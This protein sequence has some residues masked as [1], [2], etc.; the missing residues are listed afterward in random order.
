M[1]IP[2]AHPQP[3]SPL[4]QSHSL[5]MFRDNLSVSSSRVKNS[6]PLNIGP[7]GCPETSVRN[8]HYSLRNNPEE[9]SSQTSVCHSLVALRIS[10]NGLISFWET[11]GFYTN[12]ENPHILWNLQLRCHVYKNMTL[13]S[14]CS[15]INPVSPLPNIF[16][17]SLLILSSRLRLDLPSCLSPSGLPAK[18]LHAFLFSP[19]TCHVPCLSSL[20]I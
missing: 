11:D 14:I 13:G 5:P 18:T 2:L 20:L 17:R 12:Q 15:H 10:S 6:S 4:W 8:Y 1:T 16:L 7:I 3:P 19:H 9:R